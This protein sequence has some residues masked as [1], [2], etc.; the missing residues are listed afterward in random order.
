MPGQQHA[1]RG[2]PF[3]PDDLLLQQLDFLPHAALFF[4]L[5]RDG[6]ARAA[7]LV[8]HVAERVA[9]GARAR[10]TAWRSRGGVR[11]SPAPT[12][13][14]SARGAAA[15]AASA[16]RRSP[17]GPG[18]PAS[19]CPEIS[20]IACDRSRRRGPTPSRSECR[21]SPSRAA[22]H[23]RTSRWRVSSTVSPTSAAVSRHDPVG[24]ST[25]VTTLPSGSGSAQELVESGA[26][27]RPL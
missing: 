20:R 7:Q 4:D 15:T 10:A 23:G 22:G 16:G 3:L 24:S 5:P 26:A 9:A 18:G 12:R 1:D 8:H 25:T 13:S 6:F 17:R 21:R 11:R 14:A 2:Q 19:R 27:G